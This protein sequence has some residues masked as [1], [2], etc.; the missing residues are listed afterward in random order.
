MSPAIKRLSER[1][2]GEWVAV[3][4]TALLE[5][6]EG[7]DLEGAGDGTPGTPSASDELEL[8]AAKY[9]G[10]SPPL[11]DEEREIGESLLRYLE[12]AREAAKWQRRVA[13]R[14]PWRAAGTLGGEPHDKVARWI[15]WVADRLSA[16]PMGGDA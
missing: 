14:G 7:R 8:L 2:E 9:R 10:A 6:G 4:E 3:D 15:A 12:G 11:T 13:G 16:K 1:S 5:D